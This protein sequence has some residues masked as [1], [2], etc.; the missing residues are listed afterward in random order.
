MKDKIEEWKEEEAIEKLI[1]LLE[2][3]DREER[4]EAA[5]ALGLLGSREALTILMEHIRNDPA[6]TV[7][8]NAAL[9]LSN[10]E[11]ESCKKALEDASH[12]E[13]WEVRHDTAIAM[14][15][16][17]DGTFEE[18]LCSLIE[19]SENEVRKKAIES[20]GRIADKDKISELK[21]FLEDESLK[22]NAAK[23]ISEIGTEKAVEPLKDL[24]YGGSQEVREIAINGLGDID[25]E[26]T[27]DVLVEALKDDSWRIREETV[28]L[29]G[30]KNGESHIEYLI[31]RLEDKNSY[32]VE[33]ALRALGTINGDEVIYHIEDKIE[34]EEP[35]VRIAAAEA[36]EKINSQK[37]AEILLEFLEYENNPRV[38]WSLSDSLS[39]LSENILGE[40]EGEMDS[41][42][43]DK[44]IF[45]SV[46]M[47]KAGFSNYADRVIDLLDS[48][49]WKIRQKAAEALMSLDPS[50]LTKKTR[51]H[52]FKA[53]RER[54]S[55][56]DKWVKARSI[57]TLAD[58]TTRCEEGIDRKSIKEEIL[59]MKSTEVDEDVLEAVKDAEKLFDQL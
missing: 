23:A 45:V 52:L 8:A 43:E 15:G 32:V 26:E 31:E 57:R 20:L 56:N 25:S 18:R 28:K 10:F 6:S 35:G 41:V 58:L 36:L 40:L 7:R 44:K 22:I 14:G 9:A 30:E 17:E 34:S 11:D 21:R 19:D 12:D 46:S 13:D 53:L 49:G 27:I 51:K 33:A 48:E 1:D 50:D 37:S 59:E 42:S 29:I 5:K 3:G 39:A 38:L 47:T 24:Y 16:F 2:E 55:D 54:L 4:E